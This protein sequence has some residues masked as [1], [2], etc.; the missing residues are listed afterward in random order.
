[1]VA[2]VVF[3]SSIQ[4]SIKIFLSSLVHCWL[5]FI[6]PIFCYDVNKEE[7]ICSPLLH[8]VSGTVILLVRNAKESQHLLPVVLYYNDFVRLAEFDR[9][10]EAFREEMVRRNDRVLNHRDFTMEI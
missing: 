1:M 2:V 6:E 3:V 5:E 10:I 4:F 8:I 9:D 7:L